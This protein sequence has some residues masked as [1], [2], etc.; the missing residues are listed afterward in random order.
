VSATGDLDAAIECHHEALAAFVA[1]D[2]EPLKAAYSQREDVSL[3]NPFGPPARGPTQIAETM[4]RAAAHYRD[5]TA[6][7]FEE[8]SRYA[9]ADLAYTVEIERFETK[10]GGREDVAPVALRVTT[11][12]RLEEGDWKIVHR[13]ADPILAARP[14]ESVIQ[15]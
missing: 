9:V 1:G 5:G 15:Q 11:I 14:A 13:H 7:G 10:I 8:V 3:A 2:P 12:F 4:E 6:T